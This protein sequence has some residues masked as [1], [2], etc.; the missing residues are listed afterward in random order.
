MPHRTRSIRTCAALDR[1]L[2]QCDAGIGHYL[3]LRHAAAS[4]REP[5]AL[6]RT[7]EVVELLPAFGTPCISFRSRAARLRPQA[8]N[9]EH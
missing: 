7:Y 9:F 1:H 4:P 3:K 2:P 6:M 5:N 8:P